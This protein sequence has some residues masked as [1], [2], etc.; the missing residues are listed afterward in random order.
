MSDP[1]PPHPHLPHPHPLPPH[2][3][4]PTPHLPPLPYLA[5]RNAAFVSVRTVGQL[6][7]GVKCRIKASP[8]DE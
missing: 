3:P 5:W 8:S 7:S 2:P 1:H 4:P 6:I